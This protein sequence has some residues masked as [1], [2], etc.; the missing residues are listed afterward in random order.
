MKKIEYGINN[1]MEIII[2]QRIELI[3]IIQT[4]CGYWDNLSIRFYEKAL[5]QCKYKDN[6][7]EY[8]EKYKKNETID[9]F[10]KLCN[11]ETDISAFLTL[12]LNYSAPPLLNKNIN[13]KENEYECFIDS[14]K[15]YYTETKFDCFFENNQNEYNK[16]I[17]DF[18]YELSNE[19]DIIFD[20]LDINSI[21]YKV[22]I[23]PLV[24]GNFG[25]NTFTENYVIISPIGYKNDKYI[26]NSKESIKNIIWHEIAHTVINDLTKKYYNQVKFE[27]VKIPEIYVNNLYNNWETIVNEYIVRAIA[28][29]MEKNNDCAKGL[30]EW[31]IKNGFNEIENVRNFI[32]ENCIKNNK[33]NKK[34]K[35]E[36]LIEFVIEKILKSDCI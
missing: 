21:N 29:I 18:G 7:K 25:I 8:F 22:I 26:F 31:E 14:I 9:L 2:D 11:E 19:I 30:L 15:K 24:L 27:N 28:N 33:F 4:L 10:N 5:F 36:K 1:K 17:Y 6:I 23:S 20:I 13:C 3:T 16:I 32:L 35:Y 12:V 34:D